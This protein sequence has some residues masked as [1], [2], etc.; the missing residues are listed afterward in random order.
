MLS[1]HAIC[2][3]HK[4]ALYT[5]SGSHTPRHFLSAGGDGWITEW[6]FDAPET[7]RV[8]ANVDSKIFSLA[9]A[10]PEWPDQMILAGNMLGGLHWV[11][12]LRPTEGRNVLHHSKGI[13]DIIWLGNEVFTAGGDGMFTRWDAAQQ[14][15]VESFQLS[16]RSLRSIAYNPITGIFAIGA[17]DGN[18]Y[19]IQKSDFSLLSQVAAHQFAVFSVLWSPDG[20]VLYSGGRDALLKSWVNFNTNTSSQPAHL[21]TINHLALSPDGQY[22]ASASRDKSIKI[23]RANDLSLLKVLETFRDHGHLNSVNRLRWTHEG[24]LSCSDDRTILIWA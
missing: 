12:R 6:N 17:S 11:N 23:W 22:L 2:S 14:R 24:L 20:Q 7:G 10:P 16:N 3:G 19:Y 21:Y 4:A 5:L 1:R 8:V 9:I 15:A 18:I 13:Y